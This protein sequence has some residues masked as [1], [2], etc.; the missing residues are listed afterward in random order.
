MDRI[1]FKIRR[2]PRYY[3]PRWGNCK[4]ASDIHGA[5]VVGVDYVERSRHGTY[6]WINVLEAFQ[7]YYWWV[8]RFKDWFYFWHLSSLSGCKRSTYAWGDQVSWGTVYT[9]GYYWPYVISDTLPLSFQ[10]IIVWL[11]NWV[12]FRPI[13]YGLNCL[14]V[15]PEGYSLQPTVHGSLTC[16]VVEVGALRVTLQYSLIWTSRLR[17]FERANALHLHAKPL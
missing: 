3:Q 7:G 16:L 6:H 4:E 8:N 1:L 9:E 17:D 15:W 14:E 5:G 13:R 10:N 11:R 12:R 2:H